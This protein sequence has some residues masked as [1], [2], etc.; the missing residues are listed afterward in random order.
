MIPKGSTVIAAV[1]GGFDSLCMLYVLN[2]IKNQ[3]F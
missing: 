2:E 1:S 3:R